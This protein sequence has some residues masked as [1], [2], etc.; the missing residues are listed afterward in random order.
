MS[1]CSSESCFAVKGARIGS[2][3]G[4]SFGLPMV[5]AQWPHLQPF[6][7]ALTAGVLAPIGRDGA[8]DFPVTAVTYESATAFPFCRVVWR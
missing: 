6:A 8:L 7:E 4:L 5:G 2:A 3:D 1:S